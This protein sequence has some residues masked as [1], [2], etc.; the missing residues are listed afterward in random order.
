MELVGRSQVSLP[1]LVRGLFDDAA[2]FPPGNAAMPEAVTAHA[3]YRQAWY[4]DLV[5]LFVCPRGRLGEL[6]VA[7]FCPVPVAMTVPGGAPE[8]AASVAHA[9]TLP[10]IQLQAIELPVPAGQLP[11]AIDLLAASDL[12]CYVEIALAELTPAVAVRL[13]E[14]GLGLK[15]RTGGTSAAAFPGP[16]AL[17]RA[18]TVAI[19]AGGRFKCTAGLHNAI[20]HTDPVTGFAHHGFLNVLLAVQAALTEADPSGPLRSTD[21]AMLARHAGALS[22]AEVTDLRAR[23]T[24]IGSCSIIEPLTD[25]TNLGVVATP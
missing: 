25:L 14:A 18:I 4:A 22:A 15:L 2:L 10:R 13:A 6:D 16:D 23:F 19:E 12:A 24:S 9:A 1:G 21:S 20:A 17:G 11:A 7:A 3:G 8:L 5:G